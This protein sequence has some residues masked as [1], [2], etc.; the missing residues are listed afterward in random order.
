MTEGSTGRTMVQLEDGKWYYYH[1]EGAYYII[2][3][4]AK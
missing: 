1:R 3:E 4:E 2:E